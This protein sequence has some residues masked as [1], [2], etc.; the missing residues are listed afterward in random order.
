VNRLWEDCIA[1]IFRVEN[2]RARNQRESA[3]T[4]SRWFLDRG[5][6]TLKMKAIHSSETSVHTRSTRHHIP[7]EDIFQNPIKS[8]H[9]CAVLMWPVT[10]HV[11]P[12]QP[13]TRSPSGSP[14]HVTAYIYIYGTGASASPSH[15]IGTRLGASP[16]AAGGSNYSNGMVSTLP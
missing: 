4:C 6:S 5:F 7:E 11:S 9:Y 8:L 12:Q 15:T 10:R 2:P 14:A 1:S 13:H 16:C 3:A